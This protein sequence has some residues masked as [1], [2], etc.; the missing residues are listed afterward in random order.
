MTK[1]VVANTGVRHLRG[2][3]SDFAVCREMTEAFRAN[4]PQLETIHELVVLKATYPIR[5][6]LHL[7]YSLAGLPSMSDDASR[8]IEQIV[9]FGSDPDKIGL[10]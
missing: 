9:A 4:P 6:A 3:R 8:I 5:S 1:D 10:P 7:P 2:I